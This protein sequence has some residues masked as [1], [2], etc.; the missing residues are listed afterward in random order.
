MFRVSLRKIVPVPNP[1]SRAEHLE[2]IQQYKDADDELRRICK[3]KGIPVP[4]MIC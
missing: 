2:K 3:E 4:V 1:M